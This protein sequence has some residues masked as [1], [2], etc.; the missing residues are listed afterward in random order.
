MTPNANDLTLASEKGILNIRVLILVETPKGYIFEKHE[1]GYLF[2]I[3]GRVQFDETTEAAAHRELEEEIQNGEI[4]LSLRG[5]IENFYKT[6]GSL[7]HEFNFVYYGK[8]NQEINLE[9]LESGHSGF[10]YV[11][12]E[13]AHGLDIKPNILSESLA[14]ETFFH[15][16]NRDELLEEE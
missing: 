14:T 2:A 15:L 7:Y 13:T 3:G 6:R 9:K 1:D 16:V 4:E 5:I 12:P 8:L 10:A 11:T